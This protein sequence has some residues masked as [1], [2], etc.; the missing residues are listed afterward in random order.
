MSLLRCYFLSLSL[1]FLLVGFSKGDNI[2]SN[3]IINNHYISGKI[4]VTGNVTHTIKSLNDIEQSF[5]ER[6][7]EISEDSGLKGKGLLLK[8]ND[9]I[10]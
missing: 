6:S 1:V 8:T 5:K 2:K 9:D 10:Y 3:S 7:F 4:G